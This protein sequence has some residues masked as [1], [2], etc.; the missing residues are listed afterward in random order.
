MLVSKLC[1][2]QDFKTEWFKNCSAK[3]KEPF[4]YHRKLW[5]FC[6]I[7]QGLLE[8]GLLQPGKKGLGFAVGKEP[9]S[10]AFASHGC[11]I[12]ATDLEF[13]K[14]QAQGWTSSNQH[15]NSLAD[16]NE[17]GICEP[18]LFKSLVTFKYLDMNKIDPTL[19]N[20]F[21]FTW[22]SCAFEHCGSI[23]LG[24]QFIINQ[25]NCLKPGGVA[26]HTTEYNL[27]SNQKTIEK[28]L[29]VLFRKQDFEWM[30]NELRSLGH[31]INIDYTVGKGE[32][33][34][35]VAD[36]T[37]DTSYHLRLK[38]GSYITTSIGLIIRKSSK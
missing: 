26:I 28:G 25:M 24:K 12:T 18:D 33:E 11:N 34:S 29:T 4:K 7:Y 17:R 30:V 35:Y 6:Y 23:D 9:L 36:L 37:N 22:S 1:N 21:D 19:A 16:L 5:E 27:S 38:L 20:S 10:A 13:E 8:R 32:I 14:A 15:C 31:L 2:E 3:L